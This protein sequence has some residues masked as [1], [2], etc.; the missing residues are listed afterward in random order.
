MSALEDALC[1]LGKSPQLVDLEAPGR[2]RWTLTRTL[3]ELYARYGLSGMGGATD[4]RSIRDFRRL[5]LAQVMM[6]HR[7]ASTR[8]IARF[9]GYGSPDAMCHAFAKAGF[10]SPGRMR[11]S[12]RV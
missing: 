9:V 10:V 12:A 1:S 6:T 3:H 5:R 4:W 2:S 11:E 8:E 7:R